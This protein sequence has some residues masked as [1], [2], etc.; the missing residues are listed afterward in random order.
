MHYLRIFLI[1]LAITLEF[2]P[3]VCAVKHY[4][5]LAPFGLIVLAGYRISLSLYIHAYIE[6][7]IS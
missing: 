7:G 1:H 3:C 4:L 5:H 6:D 2:K